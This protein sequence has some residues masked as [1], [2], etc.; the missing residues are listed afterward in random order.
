[1]IKRTERGWAGHFICG[2]RCKYHRNTLLEYNDLKIIVSTVGAFVN[3][4]KIEPIG[5]IDRFYETMAFRARKDDCYWEIDVWNEIEFISNWAI[6]AKSTEDL[7]IH[8]DNLADEMHENVISE[9]SEMMING[10][11]GEQNEPI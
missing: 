3:L 4:L 2:D 7:P 8:V 6:C 5:S 10:K 9:I 1:M 11:I